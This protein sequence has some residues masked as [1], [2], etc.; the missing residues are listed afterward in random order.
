M[1]HPIRTQ[2]TWFVSFVDTYQVRSSTGLATVAATMDEVDI[3][4]TK[5]DTHN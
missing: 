1:R 5:L 2:A 4:L 3:I